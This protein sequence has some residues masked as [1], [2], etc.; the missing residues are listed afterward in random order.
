MKKIICTIFIAILVLNCITA[1]ADE[2]TFRDIPWG[3][4]MSE[5][6]RQL[7][8]DTLYVL[9]DTQIRRWK[10]IEEEFDTGHMSDYPDGYEAY[11]FG[12][13]GIKV[14]GYDVQPI[15][16]CV[17]GMTDSGEVLMGKDQSVFYMAQYQFD[18]ID[19]ESA[20]LDLKEKL[21]SLYGKGYNKQSSETGIYATESSS[22]RYSK[23]LTATTWLGD[24]G[25]AVELYCVMYDKPDA[26]PT[27]NIVAICYGKPEMDAYIDSL[28][29]AIY[30]QNLETEHS[31]RSSDTS[32][33]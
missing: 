11:Y 24:N 17:Y 9:E 3:V 26:S 29:E 28:Q 15:I 10:G 33:L 4:S 18:V 2:I 13:N 19:H 23:T 14:A 30:Q 12:D 1:I 8:S 27:G 20:Y 6:E 21:S 16:Y 22:G 32:G 25:T 7:G 5:I 31:S